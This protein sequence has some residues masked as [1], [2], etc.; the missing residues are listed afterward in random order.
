PEGD[1][2][3]P[4]LEVGPQHPGQA[5]QL[6]GLH[7]VALVGHGRA[8]LLALAERLLR[9]PHLR[10]LEVADLD[11]DG[12]DGGADDG[13]GPEV[14][15]VPVARH[16]L[17]RGH[18]DEAEPLAHAALDRG[19]DV[20]VRAYRA[21]QLAYRHRGPSGAQTGPVAVGLQAPEGEL[22]PERRGLGV[23]AV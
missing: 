2:L 9:L 13:A 18:R 6:L 21:R 8:A 14:L 12:L 1:V 3:E 11:G 17:G 20:R 22:D 15:G 5:G 16:D 7:R 10:A 23:D 19:V 4:G